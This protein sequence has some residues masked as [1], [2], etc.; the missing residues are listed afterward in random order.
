MTRAEFI[1]RLADKL[2]HLPADE[3]DATVRKIIDRLS[4]ALQNGDRV[5]YRRNEM[6]Y[7][8]CIKSFPNK[9]YYV[10]II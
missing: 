9:R 4:L 8:I 7:Q 6:L 10:K 3:I 2:G 1:N 5:N